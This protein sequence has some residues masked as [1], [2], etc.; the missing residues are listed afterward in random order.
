M[1][2]S[3]F[4]GGAAWAASAAHEP[5]SA[6]PSQQEVRVLLVSPF[7]AQW[8]TRAWGQLSDLPVALD[9][10]HRAA[11]SDEPSQQ[12]LASLGRARAV[13]V[14]AWLSIDAPPAGA[15]RTAPD[16]V[17][18][19]LIYE[20]SEQRLH[21]R[22]VASAWSGLDADDRSAALEVAALTLRSVLRARLV[23]AAPAPPEPEPVRAF[24]FRA[25]AGAGWQLDGQT[26]RGALSVGG[27]LG[28][29]G[30]SWSLS[31]AGWWG[32]DADIEAGPATLRVA[33]HA[34]FV[35]AR[36]LA[37]Q[38]AA[39]DLGALARGGLAL[40]RRTTRAESELAVPLPDS[41]LTSAL[42]GLG[43]VGRWRATDEH[44]L[45]LVAAANAHSAPPLYT[46]EIVQTGTRRE[47]ALW[48]LQPSLSL[49]WAM[50][51]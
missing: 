51:F 43:A 41:N 39:I 35:E 17:T 10:E 7:A 29:A 5:E 47:Y 30:P 28:I 36:Y 16:A 38:F 6:A 50:T 24:G 20:T 9:S 48:K 22:Q 12:T 37:I 32:L 44:A 49:A 19:V 27:E 45:E 34:L 21:E 1:L 31:L 42:F 25:A 11:G 14:V 26:P 18:R 3:W 33:R 2:L 15:L 23:E 4:A 46:I 40:M 8:R 13:D